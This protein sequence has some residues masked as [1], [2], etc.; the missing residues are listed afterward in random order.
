MGRS[1]IQNRH[2]I[3][4]PSG[5]RNRDR[6][7][8]MP[9]TRIRGRTLSRPIR[10]R[11][12]SEN[13]GGEG[14]ARR[15]RRHVG[16]GQGPSKRAVPAAEGARQARAGRAGRSGPAGSR[17]GGSWTTF[18]TGSET[19]TL[20][21]GPR[22]IAARL[23]GSYPGTRSRRI[24]TESDTSSRGSSDRATIP[25]RPYSPGELSKGTVRSAWIPS[26]MCDRSAARPCAD[27]GDRTATGSR[28]GNRLT[29]VGNREGRA[30]RGASAHTVTRIAGSACHVPW[31]PPGSSW[32]VSPVEAPASERIDPRTHAAGA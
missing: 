27:D 14:A 1:A 10:R 15:R 20:A 26:W 24:H 22:W 13:D 30:S 19:M 6:T 5:P 32:P 31:S 28:K 4:V 8:R 25:T 16:A 18:S 17:P 7:P 21:G 9:P 11:E 2:P 3:T 23:G 12:F 29:L